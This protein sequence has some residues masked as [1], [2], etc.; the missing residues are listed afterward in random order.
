MLDNGKHFRFLVKKSI[1]F[2]HIGVPLNKLYYRF[3]NVS[4]ISHT[5]AGINKIL[6]A[7]LSFPKLSTG[8][9][10]CGTFIVRFERDVVY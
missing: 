3:E 7:T 5:D 2:N 6:R 9:R 1:K 10:G 8:V 4:K